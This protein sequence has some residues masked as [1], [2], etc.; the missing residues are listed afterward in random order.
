MRFGQD[1]RRNR[2][3]V[4]PSGSANQANVPEGISTGPTNDWLDA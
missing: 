2:P 1:V 4:L 3:I